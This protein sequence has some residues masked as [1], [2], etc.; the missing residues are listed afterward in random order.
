MKIITNFVYPPIPIRSL[1]WSA[2][3]DGQEEGP[4]HG[5]GPTENAA[6]LDLLS[7]V[8]D[9]GMVFCTRCK[10]IVHICA[11]EGCRDPSCG[12]GARP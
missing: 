6:I 5:E 7:S 4:Y 3:F 10:E 8:D 1:D 12:A 2:H 9:D 11:D